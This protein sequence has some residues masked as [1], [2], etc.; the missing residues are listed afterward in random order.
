MPK[1]LYIHNKID[2]RAERANLTQV[3]SMCAAFSSQGFNVTLA[4]PSYQGMTEE[5]AHFF[6]KNE[7]GVNIDF[8]ISIAPR[9]RIA[10]RIDKMFP[11]LWLKQELLNQE[12]DFCYLRSPTILGTC[13]K[14]GVP[15][16]YES[17][18]ATQHQGSRWLNRFFQMRVVSFSKQSNFLMLVAI[19]HALRLF[20]TKRGVCKKKDVGCS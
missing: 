12:W 10:K 1:I 3:L 11:A 20:W 14:S 7:L 15:V 18:N 19:S 8:Q 17:H 4:V 16:V 2:A 13:L 6:A 5:Q 9:P